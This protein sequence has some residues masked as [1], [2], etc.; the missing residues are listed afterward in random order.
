MRRGGTCS[1]MV[2]VKRALKRARGRWFFSGWLAIC[3]ALACTGT[4]LF[5]D[6]PAEAKGFGAYLVDVKP[7]EVF[8]G[9]DRFGPIEGNPPAQ[10]AYKG[11]Q[12]LGYVFE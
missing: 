11:D 6:L 2:A 5:G 1:G 7:D 3:V 8:P 10:A 9:A 12:L 4:A